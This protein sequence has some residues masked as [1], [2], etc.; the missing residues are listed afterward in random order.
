MKLS[1]MKEICNFVN[2]SESTV[3]DLIRL[4]NMPAGKVGGIWE[5]DTELI[6]T[7]RQKQ[8]M[9]SIGLV[10]EKPKRKYNKKKK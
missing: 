7:W 4:E 10:I 1:G 2:R 9:R 8:I 3:L 6:D 5:S